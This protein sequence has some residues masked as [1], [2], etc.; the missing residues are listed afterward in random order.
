MLHEIQPTDIADTR[1]QRWRLGD[2][3]TRCRDAANSY[4]AASR[5][6][7]AHR[8]RLMAVARRRSAFAQR[9]SAFAR[10]PEDQNTRGSLVGRVGRWAF[11]A[12]ALLL[13]QTHLGDS[14]AACLRSDARATQGYVHALEIDWNGDIADVLEAQRAELEQSTAGVRTLRGGL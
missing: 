8:D 3:I 4:R 11:D 12:R 13:G 5:I 9:L 7:S 10:S 2:L 1:A 6:P 14:L